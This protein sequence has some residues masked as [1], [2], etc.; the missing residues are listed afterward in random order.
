V[1]LRISLI[2][3]LTTSKAKLKRQRFSVITQLRPEKQIQLTRKSRPNQ[4]GDSNT[5]RK[6]KETDTLC[7][8][9]DRRPNRRFYVWAI[10][11]AYDEVALTKEKEK[12]P[13]K[14]NTVPRRNHPFITKNWNH[15]EYSLLNFSPVQ[16]TYCPTTGQTETIHQQIR[17]VQ[18]DL[19]ILQEGQ[20]LVR[21]CLTRCLCSP[22]IINI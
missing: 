2:P 22:N 8:I 4:Q 19:N 18:T 17:N 9:T 10:S 14:I 15:P 6:K 12:V 16:R 20:I 11:S 7:D 13:R 21:K 1:T 3:K 5:I